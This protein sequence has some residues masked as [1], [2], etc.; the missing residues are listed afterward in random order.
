MEAF[1]STDDG[2][3][4]AELDLGICGPGELFGARQSGLAPL[5]VADLVR[6]LD[7]LA[8]ARADAREWIER[9]PRLDAPGEE[10]LRRMVLGRYGA[11]LGLVEVG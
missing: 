10:G 6:D 5:R 9:S 2:F 1:A 8:L 7:L 11:V 4:I 3:R